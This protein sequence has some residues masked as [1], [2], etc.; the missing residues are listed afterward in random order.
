MLWTPLGTPGTESCILFI[1]PYIN[2]HNNVFQVKELGILFF[3]HLNIPNVQS[4]SQFVIQCI[5]Y[6]NEP[7]KAVF[8]INEVF[9]EGQFMGN[10]LVFSNVIKCTLKMTVKSL[11]KLYE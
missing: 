4:H 7:D 5:Q 2:S 8:Y 3:F 11:F 1:M 10:F 9:K 6:L